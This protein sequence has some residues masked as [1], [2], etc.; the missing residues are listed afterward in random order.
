MK[1]SVALILVLIFVFSSC[2][3]ALALTD[4]GISQEEAIQKIKSIIDTSSYDRF[5][6][7]YNEYDKSKVW[8]L[9]GQKHRLLTGV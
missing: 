3:P 1:K 5:D 8:E 2:I 9:S 6:I 4:S 7:Y